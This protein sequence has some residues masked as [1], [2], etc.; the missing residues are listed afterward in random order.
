MQTVLFY[1]FLNTNCLLV[2]LK[3]FSS[4]IIALKDSRYMAVARNRT[5]KDVA[6]EISCN[7]FSNVLSEVRGPNRVQIYATFGRIVTIPERDL[8]RE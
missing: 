1:V 5:K 3:V 4:N 6:K 7:L 2:F 8:S